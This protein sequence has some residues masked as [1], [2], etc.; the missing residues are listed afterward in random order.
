MSGAFVA[1][2]DLSGLSTAVRTLTLPPSTGLGAAGDS[3][4][5]SASS[6]S[7][8][9]P[10]FASLDLTCSPILPSSPTPEAALE[11]RIPAF[12]QNR[13]A[14]QARAPVRPIGESAVDADK[15]AAMA[16][17]DS[18]WANGAAR[19]DRSLS[20]G[21]AKAIDAAVG[22]PRP[23][24]PTMMVDMI[25]RLSDRGKRAIV[26]PNGHVVDPVPRP[27]TTQPVPARV[28]EPKRGR[29]VGSSLRSR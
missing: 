22:R 4:P 14:A 12:M 3:R 24:P 8:S 5:S 15:A 23:A 16:R 10:R 29:F 27:R 28:R 6:S 18:L 25:R 20:G 7:T 13:T 26:L 2:D 9:S 17:L 21:L 1:R 19:R 11:T